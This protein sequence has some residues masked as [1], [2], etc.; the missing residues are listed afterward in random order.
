MLTIP[1][2]AFR[3]GAETINKNP[4]KYN[5][6][7]ISGSIQTTYNLHIR[8]ASMPGEKDRFTTTSK[9]K[10]KL[11]S[12]LLNNKIMSSYKREKIN[13][14]DY[15]IP[16]QNSNIINLLQVNEFVPNDDEALLIA[17]NALYKNIFGNFSLMQSERPID[18]E[19]KL[20]NGDIK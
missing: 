19:R 15:K 3:I 16:T 17:I 6:S 10:P 20:R 12:N 4:V 9:T 8:G 2:K 18:I 14:Y 5:K 7:R 13:T 11:T 1:F